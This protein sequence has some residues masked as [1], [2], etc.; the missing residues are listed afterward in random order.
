MRAASDGPGGGLDDGELGVPDCKDEVNEEDDPSG[1]GHDAKDHADGAVVALVDGDGGGGDEQDGTNQV[2]EQLL[3]GGGKKT[4]MIVP[5]S[6]SSR[7][8]PRWQ[9]R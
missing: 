5:V 4:S 6:C 9:N 3:R 1:D 8:W 7:P 2:D